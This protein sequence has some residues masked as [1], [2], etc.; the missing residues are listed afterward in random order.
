MSST[1]QTATPS[2]ATPSPLAVARRQLLPA[3]GAALTLGV[4][5]NL[6]ALAMPLYSIQVY[7]RVLTSRNLTTLTMVTLITG[8]VLAVNAALD[9]LRAAVLNRV[10][11]GI[12]RT[13]AEPSFDAVLRAR[14][15]K[16]TTDAVRAFRDVASIREFI[17]SG[18]VAAFLD[19]PWV[20]V[21][22]ALTFAIHPALG[23]VA[24]CS[25]ILVAAAAVASEALTRTPLLAAA[26]HLAQAQRHSANTLRDA[27]TVSVLGMRGTMRA[28]WIGHHEAM[29]GKQVLALGLCNILLYVTKFV[30]SGVQIAIMGVAAYL[31][32]DGAIQA[33]VIFAASLMIGRALAPV[34]QTVASWRRF[35][36][37][38][39]ALA[40]LAELFSTCPACPQ[41]LELPRP[42]G[43]LSVEGI[44]AT[45]PGTDQPLLKSV[46]FEVEAGETLVVVGASGSGKSSLVRVLTGIWPVSAGGVRID[47]AALSQ[48]EP[49]LLGRHIGYVPQEITLFE[50]TIAQNIARHGEVHG[51]EVI[52]AARAAGVHEAILRL[53]QG[54]ET[55]VGIAGETLCGGM[56]QRVALARALYGGPAIVILD[57]PN[58]NLDPAGDQALAG[59]IAALKAAGK[60]VVVVSHKRG[61]VARADK[62][63]VMADGAVQ[64]FG[65]RDEVMARL[66]RPRVVAGTDMA[67]S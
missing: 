56:R 33:G 18:G 29:L 14:L 31:V 62:V 36:S 26:Q 9:C 37:A 32:I 15:A 34:E 16:P 63:L 58:S 41:V 35:V 53:P 8:F 43:S 7:D 28:I 19:L 4:F 54:Y 44:V 59:A 66:E 1:Q 65:A 46:S 52:K 48:W 27:E 5:A 40:K 22:V 60:T 38:R 30:R 20:P 64:A 39:E 45:A 21:F 6:A 55:R 50:G 67:A 3:L 17:A 51:A 57:E 12:D 23:A 25:T 10:S 42:A 13:L 61:L 49:D 47:G 2:P 11:V 24:V